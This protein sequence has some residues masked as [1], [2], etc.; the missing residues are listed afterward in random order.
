MGTRRAPDRGRRR[1]GGIC[2]WD[3]RAD[4]FGQA[5]ERCRRP[6]PS[7]VE[8]ET[9]C[10]LIQ[11]LAVVKAVHCRSDCTRPLSWLGSTSFG[12]HPRTKGARLFRRWAPA[13]NTVR[14]EGSPGGSSSH[15]GK[16]PGDLSGPRK[17]ADQ[18]VR[19][20]RIADES[21]FSSDRR[22]AGDGHTLQ[23]DG[24]CWGLAGARCAHRPWSIR[25]GDGPCDLFRDLPR[26]A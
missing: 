5:G 13:L 21:A 2:V 19:W 24:A 7:A 23:K 16:A 18:G 8:E 20:A 1:S 10:E 25:W 3:R 22:N 6:G 9:T 17:K 15:R 11:G 4:C 14:P 12:T 26:L